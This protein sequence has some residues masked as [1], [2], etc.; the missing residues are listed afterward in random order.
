MFVCDVMI[1][2]VWLCTQAKA[3]PYLGDSRNCTI[4]HHNEAWC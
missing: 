3:K 1:L 4:I 2:I